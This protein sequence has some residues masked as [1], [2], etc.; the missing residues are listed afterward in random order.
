LLFIYQNKYFIKH[1]G[2]SRIYRINS[3]IT[4]LRKIIRG[5]PAS[6]GR[7]DK[8]GG[9]KVSS[10]KKHTY[11]MPWSMENL[12]I[13][14][15]CGDISDDDGFLVCSDGFHNYLDEHEYIVPFLPVKKK[16]LTFKKL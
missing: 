2:D 15:A 5:C 11:Q 13:F 4:N 10:E 6:K 16:M 9:S 8:R 1:V 12:E 7:E 14:E 3:S